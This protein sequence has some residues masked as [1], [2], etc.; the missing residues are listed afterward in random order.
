MF[1][2]CLAVPGINMWGMWYLSL[3]TKWGL[4][5]KCGAAVTVLIWVYR[6]LY[7]CRSM[8]IGTNISCFIQRFQR[9]CHN[10]RSDLSYVFCI[11]TLTFDNYFFYNVISMHILFPY[12]SHLVMY[13]YVWL[14]NVVWHKCVM[15]GVYY[16]NTCTNP[17]GRK[18]VYYMN[19]CT[20]PLGRKWVYY[21]NTCTNPLGRKWVYY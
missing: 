8:P 18:W 12:T 14:W 9:K 2:W 4:W 19:T 13:S 3:I 20:N 11:T 16:M 21:M 1:V 5:L 6:E 7:S 15:E 10:S 17:L